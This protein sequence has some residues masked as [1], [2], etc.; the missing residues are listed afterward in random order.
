MLGRPC[1]GHDTEILGLEMNSWCF[2]KL[3]QLLMAMFWRVPFNTK[4][5]K[6]TK[7]ITLF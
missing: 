1:R 5:K 3:S 2:S 7:P 6:K 4:K